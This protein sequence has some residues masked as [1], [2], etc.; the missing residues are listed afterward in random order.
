MVVVLAPRLQQRVSQ[1]LILTPQLRQAIEIL[2]LNNLEL[3]AFIDQELERNPLLE[4][5]TSVNQG[6]P[7]TPI[8]QS[9][10]QL[11]NLKHHHL[12]VN[13]ANDLHNSERRKTFPASASTIF[14]THHNNFPGHDVIGNVTMEKGH[15]DFENPFNTVSRGMTLQDHLREQ[16]NFE[17]TNQT[18]YMIGLHLID[19]VNEEGYLTEDVHAVATQLGCKQTQIALVLN[20]LQYFDPPG[21]FARNL[22]ECL[23]LQI[24]E[25][26]PAIEILLDNLKLLAEHNFSALAKLCDMSINAISDIAEQIKTLNPKPGLTFHH[27]IAQPLIPDVYTWRQRDGSW[28]VELNNNTLPKVL[29]NSHY[30]TSVKRMARSKT[31]RHYL[32]AQLQGANW[33]VRSLDQRAKTILTVTRELVRQQKDFLISGV[34]YL[35]P[36]TLGKIAH[37]VRMHE[38][39]ISRATAGKYLATPSGIFLLKYFFPSSIRSVHGGNAHSAESVRYRI[40]CLIEQELPDTVMSDNRIAATLRCKGVDI[41]RR[42][43]AKYR[44]AMRIPSSVRRRRLKKELIMK[45]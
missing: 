21:V 36:L 1:R 13:D 4:V 38:S 35:K 25:L 6:A 23:K 27:E 15:T 42:T 34:A 5:A 41:A 3:R 33:L 37:D 29:V 10:P 17:V 14:T 32:A 44:E 40:K 8:S 24:R 26:N 11:E 43:V 30:H 19:F 18:D 28:A 20:R 12:K 39:T 31:E 7:G 45:V 2:Q 16:L 9:E 22:G